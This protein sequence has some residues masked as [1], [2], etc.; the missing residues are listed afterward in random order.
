MVEIVRRYHIHEGYSKVAGHILI[1]RIGY[2]LGVSYWIFLFCVDPQV[3]G[4]GI[5]LKD[6]FS[7]GR[8]YHVV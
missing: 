2:Y 8:I 3:E 5:N 4:G 6:L 7:C 1:F